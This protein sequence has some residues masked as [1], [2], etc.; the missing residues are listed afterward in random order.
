MKYIV[1]DGDTWER[2]AAAELGNGT[3]GAE[4]AGFNGQHQHG[5]P[6]VGSEILLPHREEAKAP[7]RPCENCGAP[8]PATAAYC[9]QC[10]ARADGGGR[11]ARAATIPA[12]RSDRELEAMY[13]ESGGSGARSDAS[14]RGG[15]PSAGGSRAGAQ[16]PS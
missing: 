5:A 13:R 14:G 16:E 9:S 6:A 1:K 3:L 2:I 8:L 7:P 4:L 15:P 10:G 12:D 11:V